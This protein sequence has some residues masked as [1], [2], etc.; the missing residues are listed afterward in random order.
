MPK[1]P[2]N[3]AALERAIRQMAGTD[4]NANEVR[5]ALSSVI[6]G[7]FWTEPSCGA[8]DR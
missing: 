5:M 6:A 7:Q 3:V 8:A 1:P 4:R 2:H